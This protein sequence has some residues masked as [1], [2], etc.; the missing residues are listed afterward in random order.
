MPGLRSASLK[1]WTF[2]ALGRTGAGS[3]AKRKEQHAAD[4]ASAANFCMGTI[5]VTDT[6]IRCLFPYYD[7]DFRE[8]GRE[9]CIGLDAS[10]LRIGT[11]RVVAAAGVLIEFGGLGRGGLRW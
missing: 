1:I 8:A 10:G 9:A 3:C 5:L 2:P 11:V 4:T 7:P 6:G